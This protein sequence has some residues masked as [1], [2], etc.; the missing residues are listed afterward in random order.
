VDAFIFAEP[1]DVVFNKT[2]NV[3]GSTFHV[4]AFLAGNEAICDL[5]ALEIDSTLVASGRQASSLNDVFPVDKFVHDV[6][7]V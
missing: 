5:I 6:A 3:H 7:I 1:L 2:A 4:A